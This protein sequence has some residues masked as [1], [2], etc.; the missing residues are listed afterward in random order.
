MARFRAVVMIQPPGFAGGLWAQRS[1]AA[2]KA[3]W[4][5]SSARAGS[6]VA[7]ARAATERLHSSR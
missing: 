4:T 3:S 5:A 2:A 1:I 7:R 6:P